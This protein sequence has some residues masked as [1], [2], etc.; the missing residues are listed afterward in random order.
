MIALSVVYD[1]QPGQMDAVLSA[2]RRMKVEVSANEPDCLVFQV[3][4]VRDRE[5]QLILY[6]VYRNERALEMHSSSAHFEAIIKG[7]VIPMLVKR[8][9]TVLDVVIE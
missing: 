7:E 5:D 1:V 2:L 8:M 6:E 4:R 3:S 9:R